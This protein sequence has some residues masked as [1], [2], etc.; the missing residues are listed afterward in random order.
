MQKIQ[1]PNMNIT[2][3]IIVS[4][5]EKNIIKPQSLPSFL[6]FT[7]PD[8]STKDSPFII[9]VAGGTASGKTS[10][11]KKISEL[12]GNERVVIISQDSYY[13]NLTKEDLLNVHNYNFDHPDSFDWELLEDQ[14]IDLRNNKSI[15][16]P[17]YDFVTHQRDLKTSKLISADVI[18]LEGILMFYKKEITDLM[19]LK[20]FVETDDDIRL[21]RRIRRD[22]KERGRDIEGV[23]FQ[24]EKFVKPAFDNYIAPSKKRADIIIPRGVAN[25]VAI[26]LIVEH[27]N[28]KLVEKKS[29]LKLRASKKLLN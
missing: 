9:G 7:I 16:I 11:C 26:K 18:I 24:Y 21:V 23:L 20:L 17:Y 5:P 13:K 4:T 3:P 10:V 15:D 8:K 25:M 22:I 12:V 19:D 29:A 27:I 2:S 28:Q 6:D 1:S 14:I